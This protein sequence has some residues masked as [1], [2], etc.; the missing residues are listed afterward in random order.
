ME[1]KN[2]L[3]M[4]DSLNDSGCKIVGKMKFNFYTFIGFSQIIN[5][6]KINKQ[7]K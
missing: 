4:N 7:I 2:D 1:Q 6:Q 5:K 3:P